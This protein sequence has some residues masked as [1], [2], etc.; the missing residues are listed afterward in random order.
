ME[1]NYVESIV[2]IIIIKSVYIPT[3]DAYVFIEDVTVRTKTLLASFDYDRYID[4]ASASSSSSSSSSEQQEGEQQED[5]TSE[6]QAVAVQKAYTVEAYLCR[7]GGDNTRIIRSFSQ[8]GLVTFCVQPDAA[9]RAD[10]I[11]IKSIESFTWIR[12]ELRIGMGMGAGGGQQQQQIVAM[13]TTRQEAIK[14]GAAYDMLTT[15]DGCGDSGDATAAAAPTF[16]SFSSLLKADFYAS[17]GKV[18]GKGS[19]ILE[20]SGAAATTATEAE[21]E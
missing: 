4:E 3:G 9:S 21:A 19:A 5:A 12:Q 13:D 2:T 16:C 11:V 15:Y 17:K 8:G 20:F 6:Q 18:T 7:G 10:G 14:N 1:V